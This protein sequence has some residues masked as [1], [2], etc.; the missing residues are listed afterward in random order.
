MDA[1]PPSPGLSACDRPSLG[2]IIK[3]PINGLTHVAGALLGVAALVVLI[4]RADTAWE[5]VGFSVYGAS[6][7]LLYTASALVHSVHCSPETE[8]KLERFD[9]AAIFLLIAGTYTPICLVTLRGPW[10]WTLLGLEWALALIGVA[11]TF[12][13]GQRMR[14]L[15]TL[16]YLA[17]GWLVLVAI[18]PLWQ[19]M[20]GPAIAWLIG[21]GVVYS[22]GAVVFFTNRPALWPTRQA[23]HEL[24]HL[25]VLAGSAC[26]FVVMYRYVA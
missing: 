26:H 24:W 14:G 22:V 19:A 8:A 10:G 15:R 9:F 17:M 2:R 5:V 20:S 21:G 6:L 16:T 25:L 23:A 13:S 4:L 12:F 1:H 18:V 3:E 7:I 11:S